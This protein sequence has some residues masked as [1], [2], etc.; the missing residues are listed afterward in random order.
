MSRP[1]RRKA[2][3]DGIDAEAFVAAYLAD[4]GFVVVERNHRASG[5][6]LDLI[7]RRG[8]A[9]RFV[10]V[11]ARR[12][13]DPSALESITPAKQRRLRR[14]AEAWLAD[15]SVQEAAFLVAVVELAPSGWTLE[16]LDDAF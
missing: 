11:K 4:E 5:G 12:P 2:Y 13:G 9:V 3:E 6:E 15:H 14:A 1:S 16:L 7:V 8:G 10:E